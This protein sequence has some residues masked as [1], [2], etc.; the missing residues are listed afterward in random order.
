[1]NCGGTVSVTVADINNGATGCNGSPYIVTRTYTL[2]DCGGL[3]TTLV[4]TITAM[5]ST[6]PIISD[7]PENI[8]VACYDEIPVADIINIIA[9]DNCTASSE[10]VISVIDTSNGG[11][12]T[13]SNPL[14]ITRVYTVSDT[15]GNSATTSQTITVEDCGA[16][17]EI[18]KEASVTSAFVSQEISFTITAINNGPQEATNIVINEQLPNGYEYISHTTLSG[19]YDEFLGVWSVDALAVGE[20]TALEITVEVLN[21]ADHTNI[22]SLE[23]IDQIDIDDTNDSDQVTLG[24]VLGIETCIKVYNLFTP[25]EVDNVNDY[26]TIDCIENFP[27][28]KLQIFNRW[29]NIVYSAYGY[30]NTWDGVS[31][32][33]ATL[34][35]ENKVPAGTYYYILDLGTGEKAMSGWIYIN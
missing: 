20:E 35:K 27:N 23:S 6:S 18:T 1:D 13:L 16:D 25:H 29:G 17:I 4:Q 28:N 21:I 14:V 31:T 30:L 10:L 32:G 19:D 5:D 12:S 7:T 24:V 2:T 33:R 15:C 22:A 26:F 11:D 3:T 9:T 8:T 34:N